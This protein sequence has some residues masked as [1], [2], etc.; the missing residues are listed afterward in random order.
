M[1]PSWIYQILS[2]PVVQ[3]LARILLTM[4]FWLSGVAKLFDF[5]SAVAEMTANNLPA[6][7]L[8][9]AITIAVQLVGSALVIW[10]GSLVWLGAGA[11]GVFT[12]MT[13]PV[14]H[15]FW[16][17]EGMEAVAKMH[18]AVEHMS[19]IGG[20]IIVAVLHAVVPHLRRK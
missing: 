2:M 16:R 5:P 8:F 19:V 14:S 10:G 17:A 18:V 15:A 3:L 6:P 20:L 12:A 9:A 13:I 4:T 11:L 7:A 1:N